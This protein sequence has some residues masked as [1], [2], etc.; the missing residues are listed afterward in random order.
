MFILTRIRSHAI[1]LLSCARSRP[2]RARKIR[3][4]RQIKKII[5]DFNTISDSVVNANVSRNLVSRWLLI[6][7][8][9]FFFFYLRNRVNY[10]V[11]INHVRGYTSVFTYLLQMNVKIY[12]FFVVLIKKCIDKYIRFV[13]TLYFITRIW[14]TKYTAVD[15]KKFINNRLTLQ[16]LDYRKH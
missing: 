6:I 14:C 9:L 1:P 2:K 13:H 8:F 15:G 4:H 3:Y 7:F 16:Y 5:L 10:K 11:I 12:V